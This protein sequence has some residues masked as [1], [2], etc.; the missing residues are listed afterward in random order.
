MGYKLTN[1]ALSSINISTYR[2]LKFNMTKMES[3]IFLPIWFFHHFCFCEWHHPPL[4]C[5]FQNVGVILCSLFHSPSAYQSPR[6]VNSASKILI[7]PIYSVDVHCHHCP[8][9]AL[10]TEKAPNL[11]YNLCGSPPLPIHSS[12]GNQNNLVGTQR[13]STLRLKAFHQLLFNPNIQSPHCGSEDPAWPII[14]IT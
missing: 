14:H 3:M 11:S 1:L 7:K 10:T 13:R 2:L 12:P 6:S 8:S 4:R 9:L 5:P